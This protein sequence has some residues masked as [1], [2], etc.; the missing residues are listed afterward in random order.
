MNDDD[1]ELEPLDD[2]EDEI[3]SIYLEEL[4]RIGCEDPVSHWISF[5][6]NSEYDICKY[7]GRVSRRLAWH[8]ETG[9]IVCCHCLKHVKRKFKRFTRKAKP[10]K[11]ER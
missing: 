9:K 10:G 1:F 8:N 5:L 7:C 3:A 11:F 4:E 6:L 2:Y